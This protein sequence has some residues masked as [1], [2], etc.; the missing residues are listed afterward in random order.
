MRY[1][2]E[3]D[4]GAHAGG[5]FPE[6]FDTEAEAEDFGND[7]LANMTAA[8]TPEE[9]AEGEESGDWYTFEVIEI[10]EPS[11]D[12]E[13]SDEHGELLRAGLDRRGRP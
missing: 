4:N 11:D 8:H 5:T 1:R 12:E 2:I 10:E 6:T 9:R 7:W 3:W 13:P